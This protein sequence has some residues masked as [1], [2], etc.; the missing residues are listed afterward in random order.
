MNGDFE[1]M[2]ALIGNIA[3]DMLIRAIESLLGRRLTEE[4]TVTARKMWGEGSSVEKIAAAF[5]EKDAENNQQ[6]TK[7]PF[8]A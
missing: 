4:E 1:R 6:I 7:R 3:G 2:A 5:S 8:K